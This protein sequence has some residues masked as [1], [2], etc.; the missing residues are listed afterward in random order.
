M[1]Q[2]RKTDPVTRRQELQWS[3]EM[4]GNRF[5][6]SVCGPSGFFGGSGTR[7]REASAGTEMVYRTA[8]QKQPPRSVKGVAGRDAIL[9]ICTV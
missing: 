9:L 3:M 7:G 4:M 8:L 1:N 5:V 2:T 6:T